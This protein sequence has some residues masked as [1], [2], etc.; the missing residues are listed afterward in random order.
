MMFVTDQK[1]ALQEM[2]RVLRPG[3]KLLITVWE[4]LNANP[5]Y[6]DLVA[7]TA[8]KISP[9]A[10]QS[11]AWPFALGDRIAFSGLFEASGISEARIEAHPGRARF[12]SIESFVRTEF[13]SWLLAEDVSETV[14]ADVIDTAQRSMSSYCD[15]D[16]AVDI[17]FN[18]VIAVAQKPT[19]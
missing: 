3:G 2:W 1:Q 17:P 8:D 16:G 19:D 5:A 6:A 4:A 15:D 7:I 10:A 12:A 13:E 9:A 11:L 14:I 18:A